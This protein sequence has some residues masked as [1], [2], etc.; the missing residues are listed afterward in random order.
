MKLKKLVE[1]IDGVVLTENNYNP[2]R[3]VAYAF[4]CD[5]MSDALMILRNSDINVCEQG[6]LCT[7]LVTTQGVK[8]AEMLDI[9][10]L[11]IVRD[12]EVNKLVIKAAEEAG[13]DMIKTPKTMFVANGIMYQNGFKEIK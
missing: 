7:G 11:V 3:E 5:L 1:I 9:K 8:T 12:K 2:E 4:S 10:T 6:V 13:I